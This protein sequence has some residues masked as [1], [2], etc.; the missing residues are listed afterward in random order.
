[1]KPNCSLLIIGE[2]GGVVRAAAE[3]AASV[4]RHDD[5]PELR[6]QLR[7]FLESPEAYIPEPRAQELLLG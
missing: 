5:T 6:Q 3:R 2:E 4:H 1:V 7:D